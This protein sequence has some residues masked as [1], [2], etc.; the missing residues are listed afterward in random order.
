M[1][2]PDPTGPDATGP[3]PAGATAPEVV[4]TPQMDE[5][6]LRGLCE[7]EVALLREMGASGHSASVIRAR[8]THLGLTQQIVMRCRLNGSW[9]SMRVC[10]ACEL[11][12]LSMGSHHRLCK[13]CQPQR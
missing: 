8:A 2:T 12:F 4:F 7:D 5:Q 9:P 10:L 13:R 11:R 1:S 6:I 3:E